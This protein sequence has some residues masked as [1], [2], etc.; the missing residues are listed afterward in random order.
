MPHNTT[1][2]GCA[3]SYQAFA[4]TLGVLIVFHMNASYQRYTSARNNVQRLA[5]N[6][7]D[8]CMQVVDCTVLVRHV[9]LLKGPVPTVPGGHVARFLGCGPR[10]YVQ[11]LHPNS[12]HPARDKRGPK[13]MDRV[14]FQRQ[15]AY[16]L[17]HIY[18]QPQAAQLLLSSADT[19]HAHAAAGI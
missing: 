9:H 7:T 4:F 6:L 8:G 15:L 3:V 1:D 5:Q 2:F 13:V 11:Q 17:L 10:L 18:S 14:G 19:H 12:L 16:H